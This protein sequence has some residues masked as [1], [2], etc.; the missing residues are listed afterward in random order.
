MDEMI[1]FSNISFGYES[2]MLLNKVCMQVN[3]GD[4]AAL[5]GANG[6]GKSTM[7]RLLLGQLTANSGEIFMMGH[8]LREFRN[9]REVGYVPQTGSLN[10]NFPATVREIVQLGLYRPVFASRP[11]K[12]DRTRQVEKALE[13]VGMRQ[14]ANRLL[15][16]LSGGQQQRVMIAKALVNE[17][18][19]LVL[20]E[21]TAGIDAPSIESL[22]ALLDQLNAT[23][24]TI[25]MITHEIERMA[26][27]FNTI[28]LLK[29]GRL[30]KIAAGEDKYV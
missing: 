28:F 12:K 2:T 22:Y 29:N 14:F 8:P 26:E 27:H 3:K 19:L 25:L 30:R 24:V 17:P 20:D 4:F 16:N 10:L 18:Q 13:T 7:L 21:P 11:A 1:L 5:V 15:S 9:W 6:A 23:G